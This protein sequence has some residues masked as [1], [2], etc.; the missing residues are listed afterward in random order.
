MGEKSCWEAFLSLF[1]SPDRAA[2]IVGDLLEESRARSGLWY[3]RI[4][5][6][7]LALSLQ[8]ARRAP[9]RCLVL[10]ALGV[11]VYFCVWS[12]LFLAMG[13]PWYPWHRM[14]EPAFWVRIALVVVCANLISGFIVGRWVSIRGT[15]ALVP[16]VLLWLVAWPTELV[17]AKLVY[18]R[19][20]VGMLAAA[21]LAFPLLG[22]VP[23]VAGGTFA[24]WQRIAA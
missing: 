16:L 20:P 18:V 3:L 14:G 7:A 24:R 22:L 15:N 17:L 23:L 9:G 11:T 12:G 10:G 19:M 13:L 8:S 6:I 1:T 4:P 2:N 21:A 5:G